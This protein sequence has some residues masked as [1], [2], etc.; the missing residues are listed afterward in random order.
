MVAEG[1]EAEADFDVLRTLGVNLVQ[2]FALG[3]PVP[4]RAFAEK[5]GLPLAG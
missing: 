1:A 4:A 5:H 2:S 3:R